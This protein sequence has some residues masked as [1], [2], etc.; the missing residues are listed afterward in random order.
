MAW[1]GWAACGQTGRPGVDVEGVGK[2]MYFKLFSFLLFPSA[3]FFLHGIF[4]PRSWIIILIVCFL[5]SIFKQDL[6]LLFFNKHTHTHTHKRRK[7]T[8]IYKRGLNHATVDCVVV[9]PQGVR[10]EV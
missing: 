10:C 6:F 1:L 2:E 4:V 3:Y 9:V 5:L 7:Y 8:P